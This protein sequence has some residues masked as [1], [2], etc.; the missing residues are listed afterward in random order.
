MSCMS[1]RIA[2]FTCLRDVKA[3]YGF[4]PTPGA[5]DSGGSF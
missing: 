1:E 5:I 4:A 3:H 2:I